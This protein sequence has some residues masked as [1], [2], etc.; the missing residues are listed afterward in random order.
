MQIC[1]HLC[2]NSVVIWLTKVFVHQHNCNNVKRLQDAI[3]QSIKYE[4]IKRLQPRNKIMICWPL[5]LDLM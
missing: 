4:I 3:V 1:S 2:Q 5:E